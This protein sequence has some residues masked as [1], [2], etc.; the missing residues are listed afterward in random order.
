MAVWT[1]S[2]YESE[3]TDA[4][5]LTMARQ[6]KKELLDAMKDPQSAGS[7]GHSMTKFQLDALLAE[8]NRDIERFDR[9][10]GTGGSVFIPVRK[11]TRM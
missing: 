11:P 8:V 5:R 3:A 2:G 1:Y 7:D 10:V 4:A 9:K 6:F